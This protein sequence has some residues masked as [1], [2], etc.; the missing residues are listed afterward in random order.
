MELAQ[1]PVSARA[2]ALLRGCVSC[3]VVAPW[4]TTATRGVLA[5][6]ATLRRPLRVPTGVPVVL[7]LH[8]G[9]KRPEEE[10]GILPPL[11]LK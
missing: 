6:F 2:T 10:R 7:I 5:R 9:A 3:G 8:K 11:N 4:T 1:L